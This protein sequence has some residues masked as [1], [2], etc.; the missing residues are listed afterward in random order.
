MLV[1]SVTSANRTPSP[2]AATTKLTDAGRSVYLRLTRKILDLHREQWSALSGDELKT[3]NRLLGKVL[4]SADES[5]E[6]LQ[7][8]AGPSRIDN[9]AT[10]RRHLVERKRDDPEEKDEEDREEDDE[11]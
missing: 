10:I 1:P 7:R 11:L 8:L 4:R 5:W 3:L 2:S 9:A 6:K